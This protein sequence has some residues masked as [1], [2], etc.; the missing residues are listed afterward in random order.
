[1]GVHVTDKVRQVPNKV[2]RNIGLNNVA[3][4]GRGAKA[5]Q[6]HN[7]WN[8]KSSDV[9]RVH[10]IF[11]T[12]YVDGLYTLHVEDLGSREGTYVNGERIHLS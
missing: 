3:T 8:C 4:A 2:R 1:M 7:D 10:A 9:T 12:T 11:S 6:K 5:L